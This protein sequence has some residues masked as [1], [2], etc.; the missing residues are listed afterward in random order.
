[1]AE[2]QKIADCLGLLDDVIAAE[3]RKLDALRQHKKGLL[4]QLFPQ[5]GEAV[6]RLRFPEFRDK[7]EWEERKAGSLFLN[8]VEKGEDPHCNMTICRGTPM[9]IAGAKKFIS[10]PFDSEQELE[11]VVQTN[12]EYIFGPDSLYLPKS[13][14]HTADGSG[15]I[16]DGF[17]I[18]LASKRWFIV[19]AELSA[20]NVWGHIAP[21]IAKQ[22]IAASQSTTGRM[23]IEM[24]VA[25][26]KD[27]SAVREQ[28]EDLGINE[29]D[30]R[31]FLSDV[32]ET[33]PIVGIPIDHVGADL[34]D[35]AQTLRVEVKLWVVRKLVEFGAPENVIYEIPEEYRPALETSP[36]PEAS[37]EFYDVSISDLIE[38]QLLCTG[39]KLFMTYTPRGGDRRQF[40]AIVGANGSLEVLGKS[41]SA[42]SYAA[43]L[44][45]QN[46]GSS[47][48]TVNG[49]TSWKTADG[50]T[51]AALRTAFLSLR[52]P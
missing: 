15:T 48:E 20:H 36:D 52:Q 35:W 4:Q 3:G 25:K 2:Q 23:L 14:I 43:L 6:P 26:A 12:A 28:F 49:W 24:V 50:K 30:I 9:I 45:L 27:D 33:R 31:R 13:L 37:K 11:R 51:L 16:P 21:Q 46:A 44:C 42:P 40:D 38:A 32:F 29:I 5:E 41:F 39:Q 34:R 1:M 22:I 10:A 19:E 7:E 8:R 18:D 17:V 47:R